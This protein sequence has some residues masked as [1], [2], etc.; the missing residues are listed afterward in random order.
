MKKY[1]IL[2]IIT[3]LIFIAEILYSIIVVFLNNN[4]FSLFLSY[5]T[6]LSAYLSAFFVVL[7]LLLP[8][9]IISLIL[10]L[11]STFKL[12]KKLYYIIILI[13]G[14]L[15]LMF[16]IINTPTL[17]IKYIWYSIKELWLISLVGI[18]LTCFSI[19]KLIN[20]KEF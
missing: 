13:L 16:N 18:S 12:N 5:V 9:N 19:V 8:I 2:A 7:I 10:L 1:K 15:C 4:S 14:M 17:S 11:I 20:L 6:G 3:S